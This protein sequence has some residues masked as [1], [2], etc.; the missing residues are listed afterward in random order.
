MN[1]IL[2][3]FIRDKQSP[4]VIEAARQGVI[5]EKSNSKNE[6]VQP[7][8]NQDKQPVANRGI[9]GLDMDRGLERYNGDEKIYLKILRSYARSTRSTLGLIET[10]TEDGINDYGIRV[11]GIK[12]ASYDIF[13]NEIGKEAEILEFAARDGN[14][15]LIQERNPAFLLNAGELLDR[16]EAMLSAIEGEN[17]RPK[18]DKPDNK[19]LL[20]LLAACDIY[21][22]K[23][24][25]A[26]MTEIEE[27]QYTADD[28]L[29]VWLRENVDLVNYREI[30]EKLTDYLE[31]G[32]TS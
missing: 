25:D 3:K 29:T 14:L 4:E 11:H 5:S 23:N 31:P 19:P 26:V 7:I 17:Q 12:G 8:E 13:A 21:D 6:P 28:G 22:M 30:V 15:S 1:I 27:Y 20:R 18:K 10:V 2:N 24:A 16:I 9:T 32:Q